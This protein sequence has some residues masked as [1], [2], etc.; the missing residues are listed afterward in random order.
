[1]NYVMS[2]IHGCYEEFMEMLNLINFNENDTL[3]ILGDILDRGKD[4]LKVLQYIKDKKNIHLLLGNH[5][6]MMLDYYKEKEIKESNKNCFESQGLWFLDTCLEAKELW[7]SNGGNISYSQLEGLPK[8]EFKEC[9]NYIKSAKLFKVIEINKVSYL[10]VHAGIY[11]DYED[12]IEKLLKSQTKNDIVWIRSRFFKSEYKYPFKI[13]FGH[14]PVNYVY[15]ELSS[16]DKMLKELK[17]ESLLEKY[18]PNKIIYFNNKIGID[19]GCV[20]GGNLTCLRLEDLKEF[21]VSKKEG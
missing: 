17:K 7:F 6:C 18:E 4:P 1:M 14:T 16:Y 9:F 21:F 15:D 13:I 3:Y 8:D 20:F 2:D 19:G 12:N 11:P 10:L 5:E